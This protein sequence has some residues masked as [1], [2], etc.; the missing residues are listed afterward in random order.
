MI[1]L[2]LVVS[3]DA[4]HYREPVPGF[5]EIPHGPASAWD[6]HAVL[7]ANAFANTDRQTLIWYSNW[8]TSKT[9]AVPQI[10]KPLSADATRKAPAVGLAVLP[11]D[12]F[13]YFS[14]LLPVSRQR[15]PAADAKIG[16]SCLSKSL[17]LSQPSTPGRPTSTGWASGKP[18]ETCPRR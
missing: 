2:G 15:N 7:Q 13:G 6:A 9:D 16:A 10:S 18:L 12:R 11:R 14:K 3:N 5:I 4:I 17:R 1:D 8:N